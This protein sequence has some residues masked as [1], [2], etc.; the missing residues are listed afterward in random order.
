MILV[1]ECRG[2]LDDP[3]DDVLPDVLGIAPSIRDFW[4]STYQ[5]LAE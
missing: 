2:R 1:E 4:T 3:V 5:A